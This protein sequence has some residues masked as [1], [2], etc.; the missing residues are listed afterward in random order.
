MTSPPPRVVTLVLVDTD[1]ALLGALPPMPVST[2]WWS[3]AWPIVDAARDRHGLE[4]VVLRILDADLPHPHGGHVTYLAEVASS[5]RPPRDLLPWPGPLDEEP[6][7][8]PWARPGGPD[9]DLRW[10]DEALHAVGLLRSGPGVQ[11]RTWN[12]SSLWRLPVDGR[13]VWL[14]HVPHF[15]GH[16]GGVIAALGSEHLPRLVAH[17]GARVLLEEIPGVDQYEAAPETLEAAVDLLV[18]LQASTA[19]R[20]DELRSLGMPDWSPA[21]LASSIADAIDRNADELEP[22]ERRLLTAFVETFPERFDRIAA[23]GLPDT[24]VHGDFGP[25]NLRAGPGSLVILDWGDSGIG[26]PLLDQPSMLA[27]VGD[28]V[29][30]RLERSW[31]D[32]WRRHLPDSDPDVARHAI[33]P[34]AAARQATIYQRFL[35]SIEPAERPY[36]AG[37]PERWLRRTA[38]LLRAE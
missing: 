2:P 31:A 16:E 18:G 27:A 4:V 13:Q 22:D 33:A 34:V 11:V 6:L 37:D 5:T 30:A 28:D 26:H 15:F 38:A 35:D 10:A 17:D 19:T 36:H 23:A 21:T 8:Q 32:A 9:D 1:G 24:L 20:V 25:Y 29:R 7:R 12:L 14:K 3:E